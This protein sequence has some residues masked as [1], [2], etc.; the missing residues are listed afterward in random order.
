MGPIPRLLVACAVS[1]LFASSPSI[2]RAEDFAASALSSLSAQSPAFPAAASAGTETAEPASEL[3]APPLSLPSFVPSWVSGRSSAAAAPATAP[4]SSADAVKA[5]EAPK[6]QSGGKSPEAAKAADGAKAAAASEKAPGA[7]KEPAEAAK[8]KA[9]AAPEKEKRWALPEA[10]RYPATRWVVD[11]GGREMRPEMA[12]SVKA[13]RQ[14]ELSPAANAGYLD[15]IARALRE[16]DKEK[17]KGWDALVAKVKAAGASGG[18]LEMVRM[19][20]SVINELPYLDGTDGTWFWPAKFFKRGSGVCKD[21]AMS[22]YILLRDAGFSVDKM[23]VMVMAESKASCG[24]RRC[25]WHVVLGADPEGAASPLILDF[26]GEY[27][28]TQRS[29]VSAEKS[30]R[31]RLAGIDPEQVS[32]ADAASTMA[33]PAQYRGGGRGLNWV[34]N[35]KGGAFVNRRSVALD[36]EKVGS[37]PDGRELVK[38]KDGRY[39]AVDRAGLSANGFER[40]AAIPKEQAECALGGACKAEKPSAPAK[41]SQAGKASKKRH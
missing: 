13:L 2:A 37:L 6:P 22:K 3:D 16:H 12:D 18:E 14:V 25:D 9:A 36:A 32:T 21:Y 35:E 33:A 4:G 26:R 7:D 5:S 30:N 15:N 20:N 1:A 28:G 38:N 8:G 24:S 29:K 23:R 39:W 11:I 10:S 41:A 34:G 31:I 27:Y 40:L 17:P 19:A